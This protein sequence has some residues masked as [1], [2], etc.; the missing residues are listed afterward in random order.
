MNTQKYAGYLVKEGYRKKASDLYFLPVESGYELSYRTSNGKIF[1]KTLN[2]SDSQKLLL[3]FKYLAEMDVSEKRRTQ[4]GAFSME[5]EKKC[6]R[7]RL[8]TVADYQ[9]RETLVIRFLHSH[10]EN[11]SLYC[12][13]PQQLAEIEK[14]LA[15]QGL[16]LFSGPTGSGK[17]T[18]MYYLAQKMQQNHQIIAIEDPVEITTSRFLQLQTNQKIGLDYEELIKVCLR[19]RP[20][21]LI[22]GEIRDAQTAEMAIRAALTGHVVFSTVH[23]MNKDGVIERLRDF[24][25]SRSELG[26]CLKGVFYQRLLPVHCSFCGKEHH[27]G[28][29]HLASNQAVLFDL[30]WMQERRLKKRTRISSWKKLMRKAWSYG[31]ITQTTYEKFQS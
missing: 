24:G 11:Q 13:F 30:L 16:F 19:H 3:Y 6:C 26:Q 31:Y 20:D 21:I 22:I 2:E 23:A 5:I 4:L 14:N 18:T 17:T 8:S 29:N 25:I 12:L 9:N 1:F 7:M 15:A 28:C 10:G 27:S